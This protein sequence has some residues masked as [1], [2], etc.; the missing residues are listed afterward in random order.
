MV[1]AEEKSHLLYDISTEGKSGIEIAE[2][3]RSDAVE[4]YRVR[5]TR[6]GPMLEIEAYPVFRKREDWM[7]AKRIARTCAAQER[8]NER[9]ARMRLDRIIQHNF[10]EYDSYVIGLDYEVEPTREQAEKDRAAF[11]RGLRK[12]YKDAGIELKWLAVTPWLTKTGRPVK[13]LHHHLVITGGVNEKA[14]R[15]LWM[16]RKNGRIHLDPLQ[17]DNNGVT[18]L[19]RYLSAHLHGTKRWTGSR[20]LEEPPVIYPKR[21]MGKSRAYKL[22]MDYEA[23]RTIFENQHK[24]YTFVSM[25]VRFSEYVDGAYIYARMRRKDAWERQFSSS[26]RKE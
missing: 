19:S 15:E 10:Q 2:T 20:N 1:Y 26:R 9:R 13:R 6:P 12:L 7:R 3:V 11:V 14:I 18:G 4:N 25:E 22:A 23:A 5:L 24:D 8:V 17:P 16:K 21:H